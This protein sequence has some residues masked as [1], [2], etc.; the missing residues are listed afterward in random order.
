MAWSHR[1][2]D[3]TVSRQAAV[4]GFVSHH[5]PAEDLRF[6]RQEGKQVI[7][8]PRYDMELEPPYAR[9]PDRADPSKR[10]RRDEIGQLRADMRPDWTALLQRMVRENRVPAAADGLLFFTDAGQ[11]VHV[12]IEEGHNGD[13]VAC[14]CEVADRDCPLR[15]VCKYPGWDLRTEDGG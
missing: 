13:I 11:G 2:E 3:E 15:V 1:Y 10:P 5:G 6:F 7:G 14:R 4:L 9:P 12:V 8:L